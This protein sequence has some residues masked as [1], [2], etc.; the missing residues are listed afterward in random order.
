MKAAKKRYHKKIPAWWGIL[1]Y[2]QPQYN[3]TRTV[4]SNWTMA[5]ALEYEVSGQL[6][7]EIE[8]ETLKEIKCQLN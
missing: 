8:V 6:I 1:K 2:Q 3:C 4:W 5:M 7:K